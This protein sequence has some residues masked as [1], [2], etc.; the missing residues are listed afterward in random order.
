[1]SPKPPHHAGSARGAQADAHFACELARQ[2][3]LALEAALVA[4]PPQSGAGGGTVRGGGGGGA[5]GGGGG[6]VGGG[7]GESLPPL[8]ALLLLGS[9]LDPGRAAAQH[10]L[11]G[12]G[13]GGGG[14]SGDGCGG[15]GGGAGGAGAEDEDQPLQAPKRARRQERGEDTGLA[16][17]THEAWLRA[18]LEPGL[19][20]AVADGKG[21]GGKGAGGPVGGGGK[22]GGGEAARRG[23][24]RLL[25]AL[26]AIVP[27]QLPEELRLHARLAKQAA[28]QLPAAADYVALARTRLKDLTGS[29]AL[30][31]AAER[32]GG[33]QSEEAKAAALLQQ[34]LDSFG[35]DGKVLPA[36]KNM[37]FFR[38]QA[39]LQYFV[40][41]LYAPPP[42]PAAPPHGDSP[43]G[44]RRRT[45]S[46]QLL[47]RFVEALKADKMPV[48]PPAAAV[49]ASSHVGGQAG[50]GG[51]GARGAAVPLAWEDA[52]LL[53]PAHAASR[54]AAELNATLA[55]LHAQ[56]MPRKAKAAAGAGAA[57]AAT[58]AG[59]AVAGAGEESEALRAAGGAAPLLKQLLHAFAQCLHAAGAGGSA[60]WAAPFV[61]WLLW[62]P[63]LASPALHA[64][65]WG[66]LRLGIAGLAGAHEEPL[67]LLL[68]HLGAAQRAHC[69]SA[70]RAPA[71]CDACD[72]H[73]RA[74][75]RGGRA[76]GGCDLEALLAQLPL[77]GGA[78]RAW[79]AR[80]GTQLLELS[81]TFD[82]ADAGG[83]PP[84]AWASPAEASGDAARPD[85]GGPAHT[86]CWL[87]PSLLQL[88]RW[89]AE[90]AALEAAQGGMRAGRSAHAAPEQDEPPPPT[91]HEA[92]ERLRRCLRQ[93]D[94]AL[95]FEGLG[96]TPPLLQ[97]R[98]TAL[99]EMETA[100]DEI[101]AA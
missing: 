76:R 26:S 97:R 16:A 98:W 30:A 86:T 32:G 91:E 48:A 100:E 34:G 39:F 69:A 25:R 44:R 56:L 89:L 66:W 55:A 57:A 54:N 50:G 62:R 65:L 82:A 15:G 53:L 90:R 46:A 59:A 71:R 45:E 51:A 99:A 37:F 43:E 78:A 19:T 9:V 36:I 88:L 73:M 83:A 79:S 93:P 41:L 52:L 24:A 63:Q 92:V 95:L 84:S 68:L 75:L 12:G 67:A 3:Q 13:G 5:A 49:S 87:P 61:E 29:D 28:A 35:R 20:T 85:E 101:A 38:R 40:P 42:A 77:M 14:G 60:R 94:V 81:G 6:A 74:V 70:G 8:A 96:D 2:Q 27:L 72:A 7:G 18:Q 80:L 10:A 11:E 21:G 31:P 47:R 23:A 1:M 17:P 33:E 64:V 4:S 22:G 58:A